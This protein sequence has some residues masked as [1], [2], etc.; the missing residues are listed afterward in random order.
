MRAS[1]PVVPGLHLA[2]LSP[3]VGLFHR[4]MGIREQLDFGKISNCFY[5]GGHAKF[6][7]PRV[8]S[9]RLGH[10]AKARRFAGGSRCAAVRRVVRSRAPAFFCVCGYRFTVARELGEGIILEVWY[11][12]CV[13]G[14]C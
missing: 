9:N 10:G 7:G 2:A 11:W 4:T 3:R 13:L 14:I 5:I 8:D 6:A 1:P 12:F